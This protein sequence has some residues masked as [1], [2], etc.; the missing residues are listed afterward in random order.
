M[1][2]N[3]ALTFSTQ[4]KAAGDKASLSDL[5]LVLG[6]SDLAGAVSVDTSGR[7]PKL[8]AQLTGKRLDLAQLQPPAKKDAADKAST[9]ETSGGTGK[10]FPTDPLPL[11]GLQALNADVKLSLAEVVTS[12]MSLTDVS[13]VATLRNGRLTLKPMALTVANST[14]QLMAVQ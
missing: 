12:A 8:T 7:L 11:D 4:A 9:A 2:A 14:M 6:N 13:A 5:R 10:V 3:V 1:P